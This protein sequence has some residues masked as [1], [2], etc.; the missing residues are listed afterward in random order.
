[1]VKLK[2]AIVSSLKHRFLQILLAIIMVQGAFS[3]AQ[4]A[5]PKSVSRIWL[6]ASSGANDSWERSWVEIRTVGVIDFDD[7]D[8]VVTDG[9]GTRLKLDSKQL[10]AIEVAWQSET[11][12]KAHETFTARDYPKTIELVKS[13]IGENTIPRWQQ[14]I[15]A[16]EMTESLVGL[17]QFGAAGRVFVS[18]CKESPPHFLYAFIPLN[19]TSDRPDGVL[20]DQAN[21]WLGNASS[22]VAQ[23]L[24]ASWLIGTSQDAGAKA[25]LEKLLRSKNLA[26]SQLAL[27]QSWRFADPRE[28]AEN[29]VTWKVQRDRFLPSIQLGPTMT[30]AHKL[31][32]ANIK[33]AAIDEWLRAFPLSQALPV[34][35]VRVKESIE[36]LFED[37]R[38][39]KELDSIRDFLK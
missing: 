30:I 6:A 13:A 4:D 39:S 12:Q 22:E 32:R 10:Q 2:D 31:E 9:S 19:F 37:I 25:T 33:D 17:K 5:M 21:E 35:T 26:V 1:V 24:G 11:A 8:L 28:V 34:K 38:L 29:F 18:L 3:F 20:I 36:E 23:L 15:L 27:A 14:K 7:R 16:T